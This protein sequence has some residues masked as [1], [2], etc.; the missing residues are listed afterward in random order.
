MSDLVKLP[1]AAL[2]GDERL[3]VVLLLDRSTSMSWRADDHSGLTRREVML[4]A[5][6]VFL[7]ELKQHPLAERIRYARSFFSRKVSSDVHVVRVSEATAITRNEYALEGGTALRDAIGTTLR[8][9]ESVLLRKP[10]YTHVYVMILSDGEERS[11][12]HWTPMAVRTLIE[13]KRAL[14]WQIEFRGM[15]EESLHQA[16]DMG[17]P[18]GQ[19]QRWHASTEGSSV[20]FNNVADHLRAMLN[21]AREGQEP[22]GHESAP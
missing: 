16:R 10:K 15:T 11:S 3:L 7:T 21:K 2:L 12:R 19:T 20:L 8:G 4:R 1:E 14:G 17:I 6:N 22:S 18:A 5:H 9:I 13:E